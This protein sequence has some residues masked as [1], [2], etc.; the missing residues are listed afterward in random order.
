MPLVTSASGGGRADPRP[1]FPPRVPESCGVQVR[2]LNPIKA[3][4]PPCRRLSLAVPPAGRIVFPRRQDVPP[5]ISPGDRPRICEL[6]PRAGLPEPSIHSPLPS[7]LLSFPPL[8]TGRLERPSRCFPA[9][10]SL[11]LLQQRQRRQGKH[12]SQKADFFVPKGTAWAVIRAVTLPH[13]RRHPSRPLPRGPPARPIPPRPR[14]SR[15]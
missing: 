8:L 4:E 15:R 3:R 10:C 13:P 11:P 2:P 14:P 6:H 9:S 1:Y 5:V 7:A 12:G